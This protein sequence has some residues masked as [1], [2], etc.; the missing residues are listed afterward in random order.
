MDTARV[1]LEGPVEVDET[2]F[3]GRRKNMS[4]SKRKNLP[5][6]RGT[7]G[8]V[9]V[10]GVKDRDTKH[11][12][13]KVVPNTARR[14]L[15]DV[16]RDHV[17]PG[18]DVYTDDSTAY[19][20][21]PGYTHGSVKHSVGEYVDGHVHTNGIESLWSMLMRAHKGTFHKIS[22]KHLQ[23]YVDEFAG[24]QNIRELDTLDQMA[25]VSGWLIGKRLKYKDLVARNG[26]SSG[27]QSA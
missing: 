3:G 2:Y 4:K 16:I 9:A 18:A 6:G 17:E 21:M 13:A 8:K 26:L 11:V 24:R 1:V 7:T 19:K 27:A 5:P 25:V 12:A 15:Q 20:D 23:R 14:T 10:V 22:P